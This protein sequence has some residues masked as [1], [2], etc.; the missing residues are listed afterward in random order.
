MP[1]FSEVFTQS[2]VPYPCTIGDI[3]RDVQSKFGITNV[4][5]MIHG[6]STFDWWLKPEQFDRLFADDG[7]QIVF[8]GDEVL[9]TQN[10]PAG[11]SKYPF[12]TLDKIGGSGAANPTPPRPAA[13][14]VNSEAA[15]KQKVA[16][17]KREL[18]AQ[19]TWRRISI[20]GFTQ[21]LITRGMDIEEAK[22]KGATLAVWADNQAKAWYNE[23][24]ATDVFTEAQ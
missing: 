6:G 3:K 2:G 23:S 7:E 1:K 5:Q 14:A 12:F 15:A 17:D 4:V 18:E 13:V 8:S 9:V 24:V 19:Y 20:Q 10:P 16:N 22:V 11:N 21:A